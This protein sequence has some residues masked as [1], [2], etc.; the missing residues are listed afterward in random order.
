MGGLSKIPW[1]DVFE[2]ED[3]AGRVGNVEIYARLSRIWDTQIIVDGPPAN[4][5]IGCFG[6]ADGTSWTAYLLA[7]VKQGE[8]TIRSIIDVADG[9]GSTLLILPKMLVVTGPDQ[10]GWVDVITG[11]TFLQHLEITAKCGTYIAESRGTKLVAHGPQ[12][13]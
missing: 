2:F 7:P 5:A 9:E 11:V 8:L 3:I 12:A 13:W 1:S 4:T 10:I 6:L